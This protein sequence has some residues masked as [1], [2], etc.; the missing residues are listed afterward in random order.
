M[1]DAG[2]LFQDNFLPYTMSNLLRSDVA[3]AEATMTKQNLGMLSALDDPILIIDPLQIALEYLELLHQDDKITMLHIGDPTFKS[4]FI[5]EIIESNVI[6]INHS[7]LDLNSFASQVDLQKIKLANPKIVVYHV[8]PAIKESEL[9]YIN[10][11][12]I[13]SFDL[14]KDDIAKYIHNR[15]QL[16]VQDKARLAEGDGNTI[17]TDK[18]ILDVE[19]EPYITTQE[20]ILDFNTVTHSV[21]H[22]K[23]IHDRSEQAQMSQKVNTAAS[24]WAMKATG[25]LDLLRTYADVLTNAF[26]ALKL[27]PFQNTV[28]ISLQTCLT[29]SQKNL[30][31]LEGTD[32]KEINF[33]KIAQTVSTK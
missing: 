1:T 29:M 31:T 19:L 30:E 5:H 16:L 21:E 25:P 20:Q 33:E 24:A 3:V 18:D 28:P 8:T 6:I 9:I 12:H 22:I 13:I 23:K 11:S 14:S 17:A 15:L 10:P 26:V 7:T 4:Q 27:C 32:K 2:V